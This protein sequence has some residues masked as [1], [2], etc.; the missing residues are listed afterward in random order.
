[1]YLAYK[2]AF[3]IPFSSN[4]PLRWLIPEHYKWFALHLQSKGYQL[5]LLSS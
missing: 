1:M 5:V 2:P 4:P 3:L